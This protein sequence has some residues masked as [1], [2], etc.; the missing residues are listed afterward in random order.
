MEKEQGI[1]S[2]TIPSSVVDSRSFHPLMLWFSVCSSRMSL[3][4]KVNSEM[5]DVEL[6]LFRTTHTRNC[7]SKSK[8]QGSRLCSVSRDL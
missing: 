1:K 5:L 8:G 6:L 2:P 7:H 4:L 3:S